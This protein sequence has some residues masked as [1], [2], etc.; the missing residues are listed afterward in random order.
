LIHPFHLDLGIEGIA[1]DLTSRLERPAF[2]Q[3]IEADIVSPRAGSQAHAQVIDTP[4]LEAGKPP[5]ARRVATTAFLHSLTQGIATGV[6]P[7]DLNLAVL[8]PDDDPMLVAKAAERLVESGWFFDWDGHRYRFKTEPQLN[9]IINDERGMVGRVKAKAELDGRI[10]QVWKTGYLKPVYFPSEAGDVDDDADKPKLVIT[11]YDAVDS[12][13]DN[14]TPPDLVRHIFDRAGSLE[15][16]RTYKNNL[17]FLGADA[18]Q[19]EN[20]VEVA[21]RYLAIGRI[22]GDA[23]RMGEFHEEQRRRLKK[24][25]EAAELEVRVAI[26][27][28]YK[29]LYYPSADA[30]HSQG[31]LAR[32]SLPAQ[33]QGEVN[34]DQTNV[35]LRVLKQLQ[36]ALTAD[37]PT[38]PAAFVKAKA[39]DAGQA[40]ISTE[41]LRR[42]FARRLGLR[43]LLDLNQ[44]KK[45]IRNG[46]SQG[47]WIYYDSATVIGYG[48]ASPLPA[49]QVGE[50][51]FLYTPE[52]ARRV[53]LRIKG[54]EEKPP[55][56]TCPVCHNPVSQCTCGLEPEV[57]TRKLIRLHAE[58]APGQAFQSLLDQCG[59]QGVARLRRL[60]VRIE[61]QGKDGAAEARALGLAIPQLGKGD[62][63]VEQ[64]FNAEFGA[65]ESLSLSYTGGWDRYKRLKQVTDP[66]GQEAAKLAV[67]TALRADFPHGLEVTSDQFQ[68]MH[69][70][71]TTLGFGRMIVDA[72]PFTEQVS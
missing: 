56:D 43:F 71:F 59:D 48:Q 61:G 14:P 9:K 13:A 31:N 28:T 38:L 23:A 11:H 33:D 70:V 62:Y 47:V 29:Y 58:G 55:E 24:M 53:G 21:Q 63:H 4:W 36:K 57:D 42:A 50:E 32:E 40:T 3:V 1:S 2:K 35:V 7:A 20:M 27:K 39:W 51:A 25:A 68:T 26:T 22:V 37:D 41:D 5:Y 49:V 8:V 44:L 30:P 45:T 17:L 54:E 12:S 10:R 65:G 66:F 60:F 52:E 16:Y 34:Q 46:V 69:E 15:G 19:V 67:R 6:D 64:S 18:D 72:E